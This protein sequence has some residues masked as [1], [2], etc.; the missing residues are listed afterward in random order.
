VTPSTFPV[1]A[2]N[3]TKTSFYLHGI[4]QT[5]YDMF[6]EALEKALQY[7]ILLQQ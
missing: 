5:H 3:Q 1:E 4:K 7:S 6:A 2:G